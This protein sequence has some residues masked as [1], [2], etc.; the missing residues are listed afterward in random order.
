MPITEGVV[1]VIYGGKSADEMVVDLL[2]RA[3]VPEKFGIEI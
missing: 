3:P 1:S 2:S